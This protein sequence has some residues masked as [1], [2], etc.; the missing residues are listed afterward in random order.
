MA[1]VV[2]DFCDRE[3]DGT[4][5]TLTI[6]EGDFIRDATERIDYVNEHGK[7]AWRVEPR[8]ECRVGPTIEYAFHMVCVGHWA[9]AAIRNG[10]IGRW[11]VRELA[12]QCEKLNKKPK[13]RGRKMTC[14]QCK[15]VT[16]ADEST[17]V[18][19]TGRRTRFCNR[20]LRFVTQ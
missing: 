10:H 17:L 1:D 15:K 20:C 4:P 3:I 9:P 11:H 18:S 14:A 16:S 8:W 19:G 2:C 6:H 12:E 5:I 7:Q 13:K